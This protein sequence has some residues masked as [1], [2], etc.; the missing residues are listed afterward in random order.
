MGILSLRSA[1]NNTS[2]GNALRMLYCVVGREEREAGKGV[3]RQR[4]SRELTV[5]GCV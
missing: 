1:G 2:R 4:G 3:R 5:K